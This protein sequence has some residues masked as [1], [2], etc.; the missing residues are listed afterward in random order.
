MPFTML[1]F[2]FIY[3]INFNYY[4][5]IIKR[6]PYSIFSLIVSIIFKKLLFNTEFFNIK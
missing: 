2:R 1:I 4:N 3:E 6:E 5:D